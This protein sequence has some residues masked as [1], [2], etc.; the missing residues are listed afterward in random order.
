MDD[1]REEWAA[2]IEQVARDGLPGPR[3]LD[4]ALDAM[5]AA[6]GIPAETLRGLR[7]GSLVAVPREPDEIITYAI[8]EAWRNTRVSGVCG[9]SLEAQWRNGFAR[10]IA[11]YRA[12][13]AAAQEPPHD[14]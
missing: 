9:M 8:R 4:V 11:A 10:E 5:E 14:R 13:L 3:D 7:D 6:L 1:M 12:M 2:V